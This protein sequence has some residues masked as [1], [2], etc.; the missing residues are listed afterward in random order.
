VPVVDWNNDEM[1]G[2]ATMRAKGMSITNADWTTAWGTAA[3]QT[4]TNGEDIIDATMKDEFDAGVFHPDG[5]EITSRCI[6]E[7]YSEYTEY[8]QPMIMAGQAVIAYWLFSP[9]EID[10]A[11]DDESN[12][13]WSFENLD[14][15]V[16]WG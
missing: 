3:E 6:P 5:A 8:S 1:K 2:R 12:L 13:D 11:G 9:D 14:R 15:I 7:P 4:A 16:T 10:A